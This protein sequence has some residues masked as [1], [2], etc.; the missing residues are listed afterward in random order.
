[1]YH[2]KCLPSLK[3]LPEQKLQCLTFIFKTRDGHELVQ[4]KH[5]NKFLPY[6]ILRTLKCSIY[7]VFMYFPIFKTLGKMNTKGRENCISEP[8]TIPQHCEN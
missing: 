8:Q 6:I 3:A 5:R 1:M 2:K 4:I 7:V